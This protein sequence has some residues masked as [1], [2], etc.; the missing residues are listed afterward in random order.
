[1]SSGKYK[2]KQWD[3]TLHLLEWPRSRTLTPSKAGKDGQQKISHPFRTEMQKGGATLEVCLAVFTKWNMP[4]PYDPAITFLD[5]LPKELKT[6]IHTKTCSHVYS[7]FVHNCQNL[8]ATNMSFSE[9]VDK[10]WYVHTV[11]DYSVLTRNELPSHE[12]TRR[13]LT[14]IL[15]NE[16]SRWEKA[17]YCMIPTI[18][19]SGKGKTMETVKRSVGEHLGGSDG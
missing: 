12:K 17:T 16:R 18:W 2:L 8:E 11:E 4:L 7:S 13:N 5:I 1:M 9:W 14:R 15:L 19:H 6:Y 10:V 3:N